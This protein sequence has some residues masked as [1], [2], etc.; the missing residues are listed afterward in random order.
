MFRLLSC[1]ALIMT[2]AACGR[3]ETPDKAAIV[4][5]P[6]TPAAAARAAA[7]IHSF[8]R[9]AEARV[10]HVALDLRANFDT[11]V[12]FGT[13]TLTVQRVPD[14]SQVV[15]DTRDLTIE[16]VATQAGQ[17]LQFSLGAA[18]R[19]LGQPLTVKL[20]S[21]VSTI[22]VTYR[23][24]PTA[25]ALQWLTPEQTAGKQSPYLYSQGQAILTR[26]WIPTQDSPGIRQ[27]YEARIVVPDRLRAVMSAEHL[28][29][30]GV[31]VN[32]GRRYD[33]RMTQ[34][35]PPYLIAIAVGDLSFR[36]AGA[37]TGVY[38]EP[39]ML[40]AAA[41]E[42]AD[43]EQ[44][45]EA[46]ESLLGPYRWGRY[47]L[48]VLPPSFPFGGME[49]PRL[50]FATPTV[51]AGDK[52]LVSLVAHELAHSW[53]GN[54]VTNAT[55]S[56]FWLNEGMTTYVE[57][58]IMEAI[59]GKE[60]ADML[61]VLQQRELADEITRL[62]GDAAPDTILHIDLAGRDPDEG[63]TQIPYDK[64][65]AFLRLLEQT[66]GR[67]RFDTFLRGYFDR[68][69]FTS[70]TTDTFVAD[71]RANLI[72]NDEAKEQALGIDDWINKPGLP[73]NAPVPHS[74]A[75]VR[76]DAQLKTFLDS[77]AAAMRTEKWSTQEWQHFLDVLPASLTRKQLDDLNATFRL[78]ERGNSEILFSWLRIAIRH[79]YEPAFPRLE[80]FLTTQ[81][82]RKFLRPLYEDLM[83]TEWGRPMAVKIYDKARP[84]Y[85]TV[86]TATLDPIVRTSKS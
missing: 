22:V 64:G 67:A 43:L 53:S 44:M 86:S 40:D 52:S 73:D 72:G 66:Y 68:H 56:D 27:T 54:L 55:W 61:L 83:K 48:L 28:T 80:R 39:A 9:P 37:R 70:V 42:F 10:S 16:S 33:F 1:L 14:A 13:A 82:R 41:S 47:D 74:D 45:V 60:R 46:A 2:V 65:A 20:P 25:A 81:G 19:I 34:P 15:L 8:A 57:S 17:P 3:T 6:T 76:V 69:A 58:R 26:T 77:G 35:I 4:T 62:G 18:D 51:I 36:A 38:T 31:S 7:D 59:Y 84:L 50:T 12:L 75:L 11:R 49:N 29:P 85:H 79:R 78:N 21:G 23:T 71:L 24:S 32:G 63:M 30:D 5:P